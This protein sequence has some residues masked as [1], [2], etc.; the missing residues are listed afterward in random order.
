MQLLDRRMLLVTTGSLL[1]AAPGSTLMTAAPAAARATGHLVGRGV[2]SAGMSGAVAILGERDAMLVDALLTIPDATRLADAIV[3]S[4]R[5]LRTVLV[6]HEHPDHI[7]GLGV[8]AAR[9]PTAQLV[10]HPAVAARVNA[11]HGSVRANFAAQMPGLISDRAVTITP[12]EGPL[13][14]EGEA[15]E[16]IG[17]MR[18]DTAV[19]T[20]VWV[21]QLSM[22][23]ANDVLF[24]GTHIFLAEALTAD[25][26][27][28]WRASLDRLARY[29]AR[30]VI[31]GHRAD[32]LTDDA[33]AFAFTRRYLDIW[34]RALGRHGDAAALRAAVMAE[35]GPLPLEFLIDLSVGAARR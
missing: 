20:A 4:G 10:A 1:A 27:D 34:Q 32:G 12:L 26:I 2:P 17:P 11:V 23:V 28:G 13:T 9:F 6:T 24:N 3:A 5:T 16:V 29:G 25:A 30:V 14:L 8:I 35:T 33:A 19:L 7:L 21:P 18:A 15:F 22:M 31:P